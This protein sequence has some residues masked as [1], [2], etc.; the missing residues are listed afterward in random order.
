MLESLQPLVVFTFNRGPE[1][2]NITVNE[3]QTYWFDI[4]ARQCETSRGFSLH[5]LLK[6][7]LI[8]AQE[9]I[10]KV[11][12]DPNYFVEKDEFA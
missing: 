5:I 2:D 1:Q 8:V 12:L 10:G 7:T 3:V 9:L 6:D 11:C 4:F